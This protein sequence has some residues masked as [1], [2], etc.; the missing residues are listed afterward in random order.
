MLV[1]ADASPLHYLILLTSTEILPVLF[2]HI[3][4]PRTVAQK[5]QHPQTPAMVRAWMATPPAW[6]DIKDVDAAPDVSLAHLDAG[7]RDTIT[8]AQA[9]QADLL[10]MDEWE[11][12]REA[13]RRALTVTG[14][15]GVLECAAQ[16]ELIDLPSAVVRLLTTNFYAPANLVRDMLVRDAERKSRPST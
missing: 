3:V 6:L 10:L 12:R 1:I 9:M 13:A 5:L 14:V 11:G 2:G 4:I 16:C 15:L 7:E 8:L